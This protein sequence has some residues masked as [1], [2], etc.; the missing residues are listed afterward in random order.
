MMGPLKLW[1]KSKGF[2]LNSKR[3]TEEKIDNSLSDMDFFCQLTY[4]AAI[5]TSGIS[6]SGLFAH[7]S[8]LPYTAARHF[9]RV[10]FVA[11]AFNHDY[12]EACNIVGQATN[13][14]DVKELLLRLSGALSSGEDVAGFLER[15]AAV[16]SESYENGYERKLDTLTKWSDAY[17]ALIMT[18][19]IVTVM[20][21][22]TLMIG[23]A[24]TMFILILSILTMI[25][26]IAGA[27]FIYRATPKEN[28][29]H[30]LSTR[31]KEQ[32][33]AKRL[34]KV[35]LAG[36]VVLAILLF[37]AGVDIGWILVCVGL[38]M[39]PL[40][41]ISKID[42][43]KINKRDI[44]IAGFLRSLGGVSQAI[45]ST[46]NEAMGRLDFR[47]LSSLRNDVQRLHNRLMARIDPDM[48][49]ARFVGETGSEQVNRS[50]RIFWDAVA[51]G[52]EPQRVSS[53][54]SDFAVKISLLRAKRG[55]IGAGF[56]W[57]V[58]VMHAV[59]SILLVFIYQILITFTGLLNSMAP[60][61]QSGQIA[62]SGIPTMLTLNS[63]DSDLG[64]LYFMIIV[65]V[66]V[67]SI[68]NAWSA[69]SINGGHMYCLTF[70]LAI[71]TI[72]SGAAFI[73][74][75][76]VVSMLFGGIT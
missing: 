38:C 7:A 17:V 44:D 11:K 75:P 34:S 18:A 3:S 21:V 69:Y 16:V 37:A 33:L 29:V 24:T 19:A 26:T 22:V 61:I 13:E 50:V 45:G 74:T 64:L 54:A 57:L 58:T 23:N 39:L 12:A 53:D 43:N 66:V 60:D 47:S 5:A 31:S 4:M 40:G 9:K 2:E 71:M 67:L 15:E 1:L 20:A 76:P 41:L 48:C 25:V 59:L 14:P 32:D 62:A 72:I 73:V 28:K 10:D 27:W 30:S 70:Y 42:D 46:V 63:S 65:I 36:A 35:T 51:M 8:N 68:S 6:R 49:W 55:M 56:L 52:G